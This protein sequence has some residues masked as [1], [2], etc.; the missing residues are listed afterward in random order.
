[1]DVEGETGSAMGEDDWVSGR[2]S[3]RVYCAGIGEAVG[4][5][6]RPISCVLTPVG[7]L[8]CGSSLNAAPVASVSFD[9]LSL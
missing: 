5:D 3:S 8:L 4:T 2:C 6:I 9:R 7:R 1:M